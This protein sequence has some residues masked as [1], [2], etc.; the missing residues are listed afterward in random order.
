MLSCALSCLVQCRDNVMSVIEEEG[1]CQ[2]VYL[3]V[4]FY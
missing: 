2:Y 1:N 4:S 3:F